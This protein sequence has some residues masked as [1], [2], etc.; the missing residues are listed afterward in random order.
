MNERAMIHSALAAAKS[1]LSHT[2]QCG[3][4]QEEFICYAIGSARDA[5]A[6]VLAR[7][8][9]ME[10]LGNTPTVYDWLRCRV[11][12]QAIQAAGQDSVQQYRHRWLD[13]LIE[14]FSK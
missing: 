7:E 4:G 8:M 6:R 12:M 14:E 10:R 3:D 13:A 5:W 1:S 2:Y 9:I 11:G